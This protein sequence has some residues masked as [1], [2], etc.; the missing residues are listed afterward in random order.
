MAY[1][2]D[3]IKVG[4]VIVV[5]LLILAGFIISIMGLKLGEPIDTYTTQLKFAGGVEPGTVVRFG[6]M[7]VGKVT[8]VGISPSDDTLIR[9]AM[10]V[11]KGLPV[12]TDSEVFINTIGFLGD[13][14]L[15]I[16][17]GSPGSPLLPP[18]GEINGMEIAGI[19]EM[20]A[21][22]QSALGKVDAA[23][24]ILN[25]SILTEDFAKLRDRVELITDKIVQ[26]LTDVDMVFNEENRGN[27]TETLAQLRALVQENRED[28]RATLQNFRSASERL[29]SLAFTLD[30]LAGENREDINLLIKEIRSTVVQ[31]RTATE[32]IDRL[33][34]ENAGDVAIT[35]DNLHA[36]TANARDFSETIADEPWRLIWR[37]RQPE[38][39]A[40]EEKEDKSIAR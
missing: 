3:E 28:V 27:I 12:K 40:L 33:V 35:I 10:I 19:N 14:Y 37:T 5:S 24:V 38:K 34:S 29:E 25:E 22:A 32:K 31:V 6:G 8:E 9:L 13:Y 11:E 2:A 21:S 17:T 7:Q 39:K 36:T 15:E 23:M 16:S 20:F 4:L 1:R 30:E 26:L 18:G